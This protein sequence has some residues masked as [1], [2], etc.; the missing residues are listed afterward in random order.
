MVAVASTVS[1]VLVPATQINK[2]GQE[3]TPLSVRMATNTKEFFKDTDA[4]DKREDVGDCTA[5]V[6][7][8]LAGQPAMSLCQSTV[9]AHLTLTLFNF[10]LSLSRLTQRS[11]SHVPRSTSAST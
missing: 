2:C 6:A 5:G 3:T 8:S 4:S 7:P 10:R 11:E 9:A 1:V